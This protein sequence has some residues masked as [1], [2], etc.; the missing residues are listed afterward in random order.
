MD[1]YQ[2]KQIRFMYQSGQIT[3]E[4]AKS[5]LEPF[6]KEFNQK[7]LEIAKKYNQKPK[8]FSFTSFVR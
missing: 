2:A 6:I 8:L 5:F 7:S 1:I 3:R 4:E